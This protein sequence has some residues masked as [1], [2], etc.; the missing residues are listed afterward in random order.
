[1]FGVVCTVSRLEQVFE[2]DQTLF[3]HILTF[4]NLL[5]ICSVAK[6]TAVTGMSNTFALEKV[7]KNETNYCEP[8]TSSLTNNFLGVTCIQ[9]LSVSPMMLEEAGNFGTSNGLNQRLQ[10]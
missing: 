2:P 9:K 4:R 7:I 1:M 5:Y 8:P 6:M 10:A 3:S